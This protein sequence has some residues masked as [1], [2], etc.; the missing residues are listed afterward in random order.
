MAEVQL[1]DITAF[2]ALH[3]LLEE[4]GAT[5]YSQLKP[6]AVVCIETPRFYFFGRVDY[7]TPLTVFFSEGA[8]VHYIPDIGK[9]LSTGKFPK[10]SEI[11]PCPL[12][13]EVG[14]WNIF[15]VYPWP[16]SLPMKRSHK[17]TED[18]E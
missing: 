17:E 14:Q 11:S 16:F 13:K 7:V 2:A 18:A 8:E 1:G 5:V 12:G 15:G 3:D 10:G 4:Q 9:V 6:Q